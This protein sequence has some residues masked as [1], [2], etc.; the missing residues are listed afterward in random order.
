MSLGKRLFLLILTLFI[1]S[2]LAVQVV[3]IRQTTVQFN[4]V[5][6][7][8][9]ASMAAIQRVAAESFHDM[10]VQ[11]ARDLLL[12]ITMAAGDSLQPGESEKFLY[13]A[14]QQDAIPDLQEFSF[15]GPD[16]RVEMSS[17]PEAKGRAI[18]PDV[19]E[20]GQKTKEVVIRED[21]GAYLLFEPLMAN[22]DMVR[23]HPEWKVGQYYGM[24]HIR[25]SK[26]RMNHVVKESDRHT[27]EGL[28]AARGVYRAARTR[29]IGV[30]ALIVASCLVAMGVL[31][32]LLIRN[33]LT[34]PIE[35]VIESLT[36]GAAQVNEASGQVAASSQS[37]A[38]GASEQASS[39][40]E[41]SAALEE[42]ASMT[43]QNADNAGH[44][45]R[46]MSEAEQMVNRGVAVM[47]RMSGTME[48]IK[49]SSAETAKIIK[50]I[51]E[52]A[53]QTNLLALN[54]AVEAARAGEAGKGFAVVAEEVR[55]LARR[56]ADAAKNTAALIEESTRH[57]DAGVNVSTDMAKDLREIQASTSKVATLISEIAAASK[58]QAQGIE[59]VNTAVSE[60]DKVV[61]GNAA[62]AE[63]SASAA[64]E[65]ESQSRDL[66][67]TIAEL[68][69]I[70]T[71]KREEGVLEAEGRSGAASPAAVPDRAAKS[72]RVEG[73]PKALPG[74]S[75]QG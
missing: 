64:Q 38:E 46:L 55:N 13:L 20:E 32:G 70:V 14:R 25:F 68:I 4:D 2:M 30:G 15:Y 16:G 41:S 37:L 43:R 7:S 19:W 6:R 60:M 42:M 23:F 12:E 58:E 74:R 51:D 8:F 21:E 9:Q 71:G 73:A 50:T 53:F 57:A 72:L 22:G 67:A 31:L 49:G 54:A 45:N 29:I 36:G 48:Q 10:S 40:E 66:D 61:Q 3:T 75:E 26:E 63:E 33:K 1:L 59:Q 27:A 47:Q 17:V 18:P 62:H 34:R 65:L 39:L 56:A 52:I 11:A 24:L 44:A 35:R 69:W 28:E 5:L